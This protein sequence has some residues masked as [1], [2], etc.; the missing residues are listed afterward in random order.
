MG[1]KYK[2]VRRNFR[3]MVRILSK[4][5]EQ[6]HKEMFRGMDLAN[7]HDQTAY[8]RQD[9]FNTICITQPIEVKNE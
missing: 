8:I 3:K 2:I 7:G 1:T 5:N 9:L 4:R 6:A